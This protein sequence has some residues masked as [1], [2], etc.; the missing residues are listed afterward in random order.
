MEEVKEPGKGSGSWMIGVAIVLVLL[1]TSIVGVRAWYN[2]NLSPVSS[3][4]TTAYFTVS[5][6]S[7]VHQIATDLSNSR[8]VRSQQAF[9]TYV[10][11]N[12]FLNKLQAGTYSLSPSMSVKTI[13]HKM[14]SGDVA[15]NLL[16]I[17][18]GKRLDQIKQAFQ[19]SGYSPIEVD[20]AFD[21][22]NYANH[23]ALAGLPQ[24]A[25]LE[26][27]LYPDSFQKQSDTP[28]TVIIRESLDEMQKRLTDGVKKGFAVH[29]LSIHQ[30]ITLASIIV[31]EA[32]KAADQQTVAQVLLTRL[33]RN[34]ALQ[35]D[36]T[37]FYASD[38]A[39]TP[40]D[41]AIDSPYN[42]YLHTGLPP[43]PISSVTKDA[44]WA[45]GHP[46]NTD[47]LFYLAGDDGKVHFSHTQ[48]EHQMAIEKYCKKAC[49]Q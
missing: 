22:K 21:A 37:A 33:S 29:G 38:I 10:I 7:S 28:A 45:A 5:S 27:Y 20:A 43:G 3:S 4:A 31:R 32:D 18:P 19:K 39:G 14:V 6:G 34:M 48:E 9:E 17:L 13:V 1:I 2:H 49:Q 16:T 44:L 11:S 23:P 24:G 8:L 41:L 15:K 35:S 25:S 40:H 26:G 47:Y 42:T 12:G 36:V 46:T 30:G